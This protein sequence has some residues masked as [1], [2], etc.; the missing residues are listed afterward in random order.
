MPKKD[1]RIDAYIAKSADFAK[2]I[3]THF[4]KLVHKA[5]PAV[6]ETIKWQM[7]QFVHH[8]N[9]CHMAAFKQHCAIGFWKRALIFGGGPRT[10]A[11]GSFGR[12]TSLADLPD[13]QTMLGYLKEAVR[14]NEEGV[15]VKRDRTPRK[16]L[17][18]PPYFKA[19]LKQ[20]ARAL[21]AFEDF[22]PS[23]QREYIE[24]ITE[25]K[26]EETRDQRIKTALD[27]ISN[28]KPR[29]WKYMSC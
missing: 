5:C 2:P 22:S 11:M 29:N 19:A 28:G 15:A 10:D 6:E 17:A 8:G 21:A 3:L 16:K 18:V 13:D 23:H 7:P 4:R 25:A 12:I 24:W 27:W 14:L 26:R 9:M 20:N 1:P